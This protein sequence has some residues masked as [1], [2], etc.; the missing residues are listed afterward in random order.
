ME[1]ETD[2]SNT[3]LNKLGSGNH[4]IAE[5]KENDDDE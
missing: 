1:T 3:E 5:D 4:K 2:A